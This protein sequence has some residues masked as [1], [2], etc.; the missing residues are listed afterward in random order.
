MSIKLVIYE[1]NNK[2]ID[3]M[4]IL[5][6]DLPKLE[7]TGIYTNTKNILEQIQLDIPDVVL[8]DI[9]IGPLNGIESTRLILNHFPSVKILIQTVFEDD[10]Y[11]FA[12]IC[13][14]ASGYILKR[15]LPNSLL[16]Y[17]EEVFGGGAPMSPVIAQKI[18]S[19][20]RHHFPVA[21]MPSDYHLS[22]RE[23][24]I[25][26]HLVDGMSYKMI[27]DKCEISIET[28]KTHFK[29][30]YEKLH[31]A[32]MTEAVAKAIYEKLT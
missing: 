25:L 24:E 12:A 26:K 11:V 10:N 22:K 19:L 20:F 27:A 21:A 17:V 4:H 16:S 13:A 31:V 14:G 2:F 1:D 30:I 28:V 15:H 3:A 8:M 23:K 9:K 29:K 6:A 5:L 32:S 7:L 18:L